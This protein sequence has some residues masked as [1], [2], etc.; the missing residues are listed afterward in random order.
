MSLDTLP[1]AALKELL[2]LTEAKRKLDLREKAQD[3]FMAFAHHVYDNFIH[4]LQCIDQ[5]ESLIHRH[6]WPA[7]FTTK[8]FV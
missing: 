6:K 5:F 2:L 4:N 8:P 1:E 7:F 3:S